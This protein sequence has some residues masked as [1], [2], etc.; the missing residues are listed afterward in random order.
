MFSY[1]NIS[2]VPYEMMAT[3][4]PLVELKEGTFTE[5]MPERSAVLLTATAKRRMRNFY[6][7]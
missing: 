7:D 5:F 4:L 1:T 6:C 3:G 2:L